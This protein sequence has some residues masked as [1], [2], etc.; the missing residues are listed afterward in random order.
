MGENEIKIFGVISSIGKDTQG[1]RVVLR[2]TQQPQNWPL[3]SI[4]LPR[5]F[6]HNNLRDFDVALGVEVE[7]EAKEEREL[8]IRIKLKG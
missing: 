8:V 5:E 3:L 2:I 1:D 7:V 6:Y 4:H